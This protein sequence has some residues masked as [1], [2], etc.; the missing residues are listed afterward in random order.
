MAASVVDLACLDGDLAAEECCDETRI[1]KVD[2]RL[3]TMMTRR[4]RRA[5]GRL[6]SSCDIDC[7]A[8]HGDDGDCC[9]CDALEVENGTCNSRHA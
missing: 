6:F 4:R 1:D 2:S 3:T 7:D 8:T 5:M 9:C